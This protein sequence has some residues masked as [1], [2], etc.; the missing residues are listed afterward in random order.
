MPKKTT[1]I[2][3]APLAVIIKKAGAARV[4]DAAAREL[5]SYLMEYAAQTARQAVEISK[6]AGRKTV[7]ESDIRIAAKKY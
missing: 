5:G 1:V 2:P 6:N 3:S 4:A 7:N